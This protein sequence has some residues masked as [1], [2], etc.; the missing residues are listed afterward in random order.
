MISRKKSEP[1]VS[2]HLIDGIRVS[3]LGTVLEIMLFDD[4][5]F[6]GWKFYPAFNYDDPVMRN[7]KQHGEA[8]GVVPWVQFALLVLP[9]EE[10]EKVKMAVKE[11]VG[12]VKDEACHAAVCYQIHT[13]IPCE[14]GNIEPQCKPFCQKT[15]GGKFDGAQCV[16]QVGFNPFCACSYTC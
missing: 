12:E 3:D 9:G 14:Q 6:S 1:E 4:E 2:R 13:E 16:E 5:L 10:Q 7:F 11:P 8:A 15:F